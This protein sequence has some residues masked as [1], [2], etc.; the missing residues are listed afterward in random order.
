MRIGVERRQRR[1]AILACRSGGPGDARPVRLPR[2][3][4]PFPRA[5]VLGA[6]RGRGCRDRRRRLADLQPRVPQLRHALR[7]DLGP[8]PGRT[9][10]RPTTRSRSRPRPS[11]GRGGRGAALAAR[12]GRRLHGDAGAGDAGLRRAGVGHLPARPRVASAGRSGALAAFVVATREPF[13]SQG[14]RAYVDIPFLALVVAAAVLEVAPAAPRGCRCSC[15]SALAGLLRPEAW[16]LGGRLLALPAAGAR[17]RPRAARSARWSLAAPLLWALSDLAITGDAA[18]LPHVHARHGRDARPA[19]GHRERA[20]DDAA[21]ARGDPALGAA[22]GRHG[23]VLPGAALRARAGRACPRRWRCSAGSRSW[24]S[25]SPACRCSAAT[26]S[27]RRRCCA[28]FFGFAALGWIGRPLDRP[29]AR[30]WVGGAAV[31]LVAFVGST[32]SHQTDRLD[33]LR[34][35]IQLRGEIQDDLRDLTRVDAAEAAA[36]ALRAGLRAEPPAGADPR[37]VPR[38]RARRTSVSAQLERAAPRPVRRAR[39]PT[40]CE[41]KFVLDP[42][43]PKRFE[44]PRQPAGFRPVAANES[45]VLYERGC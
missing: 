42:R 25:G 5:P 30:W 23:R 17:P 38:P 15:C 31:L 35:G 24:R 20:G 6:Q 16:L 41:E 19:A 44:V 27:C 10:A 34:D 28:I 32:V 1:R 18:P 33:R 37:L 12:R 29:L 43:D 14:V 13:L 21:P 8:R 2:C 39:R 26:C 9:G 11:A 40:S 22:G 36:R 45:W 4:R 7:A 3:V